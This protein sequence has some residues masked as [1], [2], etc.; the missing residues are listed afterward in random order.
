MYIN[1]HALCSLLTR[2]TNCTVL[3][4][5]WKV[6]GGEHELR[7]TECTKHEYLNNCAYKN[8]SC[9]LKQNQNNTLV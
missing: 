4:F 5:V 3:E 8:F 7:N 1:K 9:V 6:F 2:Y